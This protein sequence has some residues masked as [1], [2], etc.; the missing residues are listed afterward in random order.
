[1]III[2][3]GIYTRLSRL[4]NG[5]NTHSPPNIPYNKNA[6]DTVIIECI[7]MSKTFLTESKVT[8]LSYV[9]IMKYAK[10]SNTLIPSK[11][12]NAV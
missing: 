8:K 5:V 7:T 9:S 2:E 12:I 4:L 3:K 6:P 1:M 11:I 10:S